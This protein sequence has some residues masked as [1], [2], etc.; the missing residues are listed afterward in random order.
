MFI[1]IELQ[2]N[3]D[4]TLGNFVWTYSSLPEAESKF[5]SVLAA[6]AVSELPKHACVI[7]NE[8]GRC[9]RSQCYEH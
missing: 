9:F 4:G 5:H 3:S 7:M 8:E 6:A 2:T 1:V